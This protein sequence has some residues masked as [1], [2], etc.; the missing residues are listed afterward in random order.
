MFAQPFV[1]PICLRRL[2]L[3]T[4][5]SDSQS[6]VKLL[7]CAREVAIILPRKQSHW[8]M[9]SR[10]YL[11]LFFGHLSFSYKVGCLL[12]L[13]HPRTLPCQDACSLSSSQDMWWPISHNSPNFP[14]HS[15]LLIGLSTG[16]YENFC[17][18]TL[19]HTANQLLPLSGGGM[20][21]IDGSIQF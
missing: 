5:R 1:R 18:N 7:H 16:D 14:K 12:L 8:T 11:Q 10:K 17:L 2:G 9:P 15:Q 4:F 21:S 19:V 3:I 20:F 6:Q 13:I